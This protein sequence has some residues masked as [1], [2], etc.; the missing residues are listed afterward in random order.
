MSNQE[1]PQTGSPETSKD[2][3]VGFSKGTYPTFTGNKEIE[4]IIHKNIAKPE[5]SVVGRLALKWRA[6]FQEGGQLS[7]KIMQISSQVAA[8]QA[9]LQSLTEEQNKLTGKITNIEET[10]LEESKLMEQKPDTTH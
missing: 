10:I 8:L 2:H 3:Q 4:E 1:I 5:N 6:T 7:N 9:E